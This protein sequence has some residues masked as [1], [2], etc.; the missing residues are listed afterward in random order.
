MLQP[1]NKKQLLPPRRDLG[2]RLLAFGCRPEEARCEGE[3]A[4]PSRLRDRQTG[5]SVKTLPP[6]AEGV[7]RPAGPLWRCLLQRG[8]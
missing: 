4:A 3:P 8:E 1:Q 6:S 7:G 5:R 2:Y